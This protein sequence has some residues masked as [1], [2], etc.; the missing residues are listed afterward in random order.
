MTPS[1]TDLHLGST[2]QSDTQ[3][4]SGDALS[5]L[6]CHP[7]PVALLVLV[8]YLVTH[9]LVGLC[10]VVRTFHKERCERRDRAH[11]RSVGDQAEAWLRRQQPTA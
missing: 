11:Q 3:R 8:L 6:Q 10:L 9:V 5:P 4:L 1:R 7:V 2:A